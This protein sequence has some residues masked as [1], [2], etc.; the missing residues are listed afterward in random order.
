MKHTPSQR[1][2]AKGP[3]AILLAALVAGIPIGVLGYCIYDDD[4]DRCHSNNIL[5][6]W[7]TT[8]PQCKPV[9]EC[10]VWNNEYCN[11]YDEDGWWESQGTGGYVDYSCEEMIYD[12]PNCV[13]PSG[14]CGPETPSGNSDTGSCWQ[15]LCSVPCG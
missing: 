4:F 10:D 14:D 1:L 12:S 11:V 6:G 9:W 8:T 15:Q 2:N 13:G 7:C 3:A 5:P